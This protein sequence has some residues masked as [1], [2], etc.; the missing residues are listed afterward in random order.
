MHIIR[1]EGD[2]YEI[3]VIDNYKDGKVVI[4]STK[5]INTER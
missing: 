5:N 1:G 2:A 3:N 4:N